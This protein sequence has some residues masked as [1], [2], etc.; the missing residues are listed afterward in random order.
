MSEEVET[1]EFIEVPVEEFKH[2]RES[3]DWHAALLTVLLLEAGGVVEVDAKE[4]EKIDLNRAQARIS[5]DEERNVFIVEGL[6]VE[7]ES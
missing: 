5:L 2:L 1:Q 7:D 6:Y 3:L 4:L